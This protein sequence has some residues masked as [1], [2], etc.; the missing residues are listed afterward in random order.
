MLTQFL[1]VNTYWSCQDMIS[2]FLITPTNMLKVKCLMSTVAILPH[3]QKNTMQGIIKT[4]QNYTVFLLHQ[5]QEC[6]F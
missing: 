5:L 6:S 2:Y 1:M 4:M 3:R